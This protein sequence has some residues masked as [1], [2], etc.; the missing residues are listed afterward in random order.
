MFEVNCDRFNLLLTFVKI[1]IY[2][3]LINKIHS[4]DPYLQFKETVKVYDNIVEVVNMKIN[5]IFDNIRKFQF[6]KEE[7]DTID[8]S[9]EDYLSLLR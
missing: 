3:K 9:I 8:Y 6:Y 2:L 5:K 7:Y 4:E 1:E